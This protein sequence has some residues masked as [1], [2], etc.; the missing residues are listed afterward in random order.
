MF[1]PQSVSPS[2][3]H[4]SNVGCHQLSIEY[5]RLFNYMEASSRTVCVTHILDFRTSR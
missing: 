2:P 4:T 3:I 1:A 5:L